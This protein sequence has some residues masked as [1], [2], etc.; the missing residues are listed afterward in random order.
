MPVNVKNPITFEEQ[1]ELWRKLADIAEKIEPPGPRRIKN[2]REKL[3]KQA[4]EILA[5][6]Q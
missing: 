4:A 5:N 1:K 6:R 3:K 2:S